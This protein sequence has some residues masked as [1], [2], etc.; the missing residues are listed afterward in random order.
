M[1]EL[2][3]LRQA[4]DIH[5]DVLNDPGIAHLFIHNNR[6]VGLKGLPGLSV[7]P[8]EL[9]DGVALTIRLA[10]GVVIPKPVHL[11]FGVLPRE[12]VQRI[13]LK[14]EIG[15]GAAISVLAHCAFPDAV[16][17]RHLMEGE[18]VLRPGARYAYHERHIHGPEGGV[19]VLPKTRVRVEEGGVFRTDFELLRGRVGRIEIDYETVCLKDAVLEMNAR[20]NASGDDVVKITETGFLEGEGSRGALTTRVALR[21]EAVAEVVTKLVASGAGSR[22]HVDCK[23]IVQDRSRASAVPIVDVRHPKAHVTHE[24]AIGSVD[25]KQLETLMAR[26]LTEDE[27]VDLIIQGLLTGA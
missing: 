27:A 25:S 1:S 9:S 15:A 20:V 12:G 26:G 14:A 23:E 22:G 21:H 17:V 6:V 19:T 4:A 10:D 16:D 2:E 11:C 18:V 13:V 24:A 7:E 5:P 3:R 8:E